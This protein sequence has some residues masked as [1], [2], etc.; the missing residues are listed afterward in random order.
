MLTD[1]DRAKAAI[2]TVNTKNSPLMLRV[3]PD[4]KTTV[5]AE[6]KKGEKCV[7]YGIYSEKWFMVDYIRNDNVIISGFA[8]S[9]YLKKGEN[10]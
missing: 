2:Y 9:D 7:C 5:L 8:H 3:M 10:I 6:M 4:T 1:F